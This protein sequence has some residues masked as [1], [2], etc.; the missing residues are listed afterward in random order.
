MAGGDD[1]DGVWTGRDSGR[2]EDNRSEWTAVTGEGEREGVSLDAGVPREEARCGKGCWSGGSTG[3]GWIGGTTGIGGTGSGTSR[4]AGCGGG[5]RE[6]RGR[7][8]S[9]GGEITLIESSFIS[10]RAY[11]SKINASALYDSGRPESDVPS[12]LSLLSKRGRRG[13]SASL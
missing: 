5:D 12:R 11:A 3:V 2:A 13:D 4:D 7:G 9:N 1:V 8:R 6:R 10:S